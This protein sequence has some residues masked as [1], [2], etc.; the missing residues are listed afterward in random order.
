[1]HIN[2]I[3]HPNCINHDVSISQSLS[4]FSNII[5]RLSIGNNQNHLWNV[6]T[7]S[8]LKPI[9]ESKLIRTFKYELIKVTCKACPVFVAPF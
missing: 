5:L 8:T 1:M 3:R 9:L 2:Q 4:R 7:T 6:S